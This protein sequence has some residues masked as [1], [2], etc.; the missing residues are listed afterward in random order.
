MTAGEL[1]TGTHVYSCRDTDNI[2][3]ALLIMQREKVRRLAVI[4]AD[5]RV[6]G[7]LSMD[8]IVAFAERGIRGEGSPD[9]SYED[10]MLTLKAVCKH[11]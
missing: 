10:A 8:D 9:L 3:E 2:R 1:V 6:L 4:D 7:L 5:G 11:H